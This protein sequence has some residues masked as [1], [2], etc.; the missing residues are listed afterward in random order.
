[1]NSL[2]LAYETVQGTDEIRTVKNGS[3]VYFALEDVVRVLASD[4]SSLSSQAERY[5]LSGL[6]QA[7]LDSL[8]HDEVLHYETV[9]RR[10]EAFVTEP[11]L[12]RV[13]MQDASPA[14]KKFQRWV[15]HDVLPSIRQ[16]GV[17]PPPKID[18]GG[19]LRVLAQRLVE[20]TNLLIKEMEERERLE[21]EVNNRFE[22]N[23]KAIRR[24][25][26]ELERMVPQNISGSE[27]LYISISE[28]SGR[29]G[30]DPESSLL[31]WAHAAK[32]CIEMQKPSLRVSE[33]REDHKFP[34]D[35][36]DLALDMLPNN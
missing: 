30:L 34:L 23:E 22:E 33:K 21:R 9:D 32:I 31:L 11:G 6:V 28:V 20:N 18:K 16:F 25:S 12:Y 17:Y 3:D 1:M 2:S 19:E 27:D 4:N 10:Q 26:N 24:I 8:D 13:V 14:A 15:V 36:I 7:T 5:G 29:E 35:V